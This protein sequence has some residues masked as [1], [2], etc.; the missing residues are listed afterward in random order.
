MHFYATA[1]VK[2]PNFMITDSAQLSENNTKYIKMYTLFQ[3]SCNLLDKCLR[4]CY[5]EVY[6]I[7][8]NTCT[9]IL[10]GIN[11]QEF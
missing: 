1:T 5:N 8:I 9:N 6:I 7:F 11:E 3:N 2:V 4:I 10:R